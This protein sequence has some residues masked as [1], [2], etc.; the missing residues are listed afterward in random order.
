MS[1]SPWILYSTLR[2]APN[3]PRSIQNIESQCPKTTKASMITLFNCKI[4]K[5][6]KNFRQ[7][8]AKLLNFA[9][10]TKE[11]VC[12]QLPSTKYFFRIYRANTQTRAYAWTSWSWDYQRENSSFTHSMLLFQDNLVKRF[13]KQRSFL[14]NFSRKIKANW[15]L[16]SST[17]SFAPKKAAFR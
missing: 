11:N 1:R 9:S 4:A 17:S 16:A 14:R 3:L 6:S 2:S 8:L 7:I 13:L 5:T 12:L 15:I 10:Y